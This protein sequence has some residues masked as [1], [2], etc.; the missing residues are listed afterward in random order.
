MTER[1]RYYFNSVIVNSFVPYLKTRGIKSVNSINVELLSDY[2]DY[3][4]SEGGS[5]SKDGLTPQTVN[6]Y[7]GAIKRMFLYLIRKNMVS[8]NPFTA[9]ERL[10]V[11]EDDQT[12]R[13]CYE[14]EKI[15]GAFNEQWKKT[16]YYILCLL[17]YSTGMRN[18]EIE[19][20]KMS[21]IIK[22]DGCY[23]IDITKSK[24]PGGVRLVPLHD[25]VLNALRLYAQGKPED[26]LVLDKLVFNYSTSSVYNSA[27]NALA[28]QLKVNEE[29]LK[30]Q[31]ITFYSGRHF[32]KTLMNS[33]GLGD[34][35]EEV[36]MGHHVSSDVAKRYNHR[37]KQ[38]RERVI[39]KAKQ[40]FA[41]LDEKLF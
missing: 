25:K 41:I 2:Q 16:Q 17:I 31:K 8:D 27:N 4:L 10:T 28:R 18:S 40:V 24:T 6:K 7:L 23:F 14:I 21:D 38:G 20:L 36:F 29:T 13:G 26:E 1:N 22:V 30:E 19:R 34:D 3:L 11:S 33:E 15:K 37:D 5:L 12:V 9:L 39:A 35:I 32:W